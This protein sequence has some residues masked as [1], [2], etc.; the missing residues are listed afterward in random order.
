MKSDNKIQ[1]L[2]HKIDI[3]NP[4]SS[5]KYM[6]DNKPVFYSSDL[7]AWIVTR[8]NEITHI[9]THPDIYSSR[10]AENILLPKWLNP[11]AIKNYKIA[12]ED[13]PTHTKHRKMISSYFVKNTIRKHIKR[14]EPIAHNLIDSIKP[15]KKIDFMCD[16]ATKYTDAVAADFVGIN[17]PTLLTPF[18]C[19][20]DLIDHPPNKVDIKYEDKLLSADKKMQVTLQSIIHNKDKHSSSGL[21]QHL[22]RQCQNEEGRIIEELV[23]LVL[24]GAMQ[25]VNHL[26]CQLII[27]LAHN[28]SVYKELKKLGISENILHEFIRLHSPNH[29][30]PRKTLSTSILCDIEIPS[31]ANILMIIASGN[32][33]ERHFFNPTELIT[34]RDNVQSHLGFGKG[35]HHCLGKGLA[36]K[37][38][39]ILLS[40]LIDKFSSISCQKTNELPWFYNLS[41]YSVE[42]LPVAFNQH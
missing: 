17:D 42:K 18:R 26:L 20:L 30:M 5:Y 12:F 22:L 36:I 37:E 34:N 39:S 33:D 31:N 23:E 19:Y 21:I 4:F 6:R 3:Y 24:I 29:F 14:I 41:A 10:G 11:R 27:F 9:I 7:N 25:P 1:L 8:Y 2:D 16:I 35:I 40:I 13:T 38:I 32:R 15:Q 28:P